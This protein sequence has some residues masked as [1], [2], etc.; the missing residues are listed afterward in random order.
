MALYLMLQTFPL[1]L[2]PS[3]TNTGSSADFWGIL[4]YPQRAIARAHGGRAS[5][6][7]SN[8]Q[9]LGAGA[10]AGGPQIRRRTFSR[11]FLD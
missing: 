11:F 2:R 8:L 7:G 1:L 3:S 6:L 4:R 10:P 5:T 9:G